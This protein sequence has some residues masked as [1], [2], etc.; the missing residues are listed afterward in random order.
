MIK[1]EIADNEEAAAELFR[2]KPAEMNHLIAKAAAAVNDMYRQLDAINNEAEKLFAGL[3]FYPGFCKPMFRAKE[4][5]DPQITIWPT[6]SAE[7]E[8]RNRSQM[9]KSRREKQSKTRQQKRKNKQ[10]LQMYELKSKLS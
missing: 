2:L 8:A 5:D 7:L 3:D 4:P 10:E 1:Y 6:E 9:Q